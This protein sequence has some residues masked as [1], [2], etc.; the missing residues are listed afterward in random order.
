MQV[1][2]AV[3]VQG[4]QRLGNDAPKPHRTL[5]VSSEG[6]QPVGDHGNLPRA[7]RIHER[8]HEALDLLPPL[9]PAHDPLV[10]SAERRE[11]QEQMCLAALEDPAVFQGKT[12][13]TG[14]TIGNNG[15][16]ALS[17]VLGNLLHNLPPPLLRLVTGLQNRMQ[18]MKLVVFNGS[19]AQEVDGL[20]PIDRFKPHRVHDEDERSSR[21]VVRPWT[22]DEK[23]ERLRVALGETSLV[24]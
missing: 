10:V 21:R 12:A 13:G 18:E 15:T 17:C 24:H 20:F 19:Q 9:P 7:P 2:G 14:E 1:A 23:S 4:A 16:N 6:E 8:V 5:S 3:L 22:F 11:A